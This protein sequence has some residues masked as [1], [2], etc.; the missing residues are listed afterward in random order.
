MLFPLV[1]TEAAANDVPFPLVE[2]VTAAR[3]HLLRI[4]P[5][6]VV[7]EDSYLW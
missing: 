6:W 2:R 1:P 4:C 7:L 5:S 3:L